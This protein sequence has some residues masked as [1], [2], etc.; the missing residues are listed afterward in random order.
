MINDE[1]TVSEMAGLW[2]RVMA[3]IEEHHISCPE[4]TSN[5]RVY[6]NSQNFIVDLCEIVGY[7]DYPDEI[8]EEE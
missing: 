5:D 3:F 6:E 4:A 1:P 7:Y 2:K 8:E